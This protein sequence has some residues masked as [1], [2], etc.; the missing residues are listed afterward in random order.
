MREE[1]KPQESIGPLS[2]LTRLELVS[3]RFPAL[4][5]RASLLASLPR[6][7]PMLVNSNRPLVTKTLGCL[8]SEGRLTQT[9]SFN[10]GLIFGKI[11][12]TSAFFGMPY[13]F[14]ACDRLTHN[15]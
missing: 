14:T 8:T 9:S 12:S 10:V 5:R 1:K 11:F 13:A 6:L 2:S 15:V 3:R 4:R 7:R